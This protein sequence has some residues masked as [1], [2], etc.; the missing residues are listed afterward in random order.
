M[1]IVLD[2]NVFVSGIF[3][4]GTDLSPKTRAAGDFSPAAEL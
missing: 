2:T 1:R 3:F 4:P